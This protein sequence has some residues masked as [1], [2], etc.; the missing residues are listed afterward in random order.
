MACTGYRPQPKTAGS[1]A[2]PGPEVVPLRA[3]ENDFV[4]NRIS[5]K[6]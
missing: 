6:D 3:T 5:G 1:N 4:N 2:G